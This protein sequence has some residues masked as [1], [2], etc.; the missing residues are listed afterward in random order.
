MAEMAP[1]FNPLF[2]YFDD[3]FVLRLENQALAEEVESLT[4]ELQRLWKQVQRYEKKLHGKK[5]RR[6]DSELKK[7]FSCPKMDCKKKYAYN[8]SLTLH[9]K[10]KHCMP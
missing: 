6:K 4:E 9:V 2:D 8:S 10:T 1:E 7:F 5:E 3:V